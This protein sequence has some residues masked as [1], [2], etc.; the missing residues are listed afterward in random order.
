MSFGRS[1]LL[2]LSAISLVSSPVV[3]Q[4][5]TSPALRVGSDVE[6]SESVAGM[7]ILI[8]IIAVLAIVLIAV[9]VNDSDSPTSP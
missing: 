5:A 2:G 6:D 3:A 8:P 9:A 7:G 1:A 4:A